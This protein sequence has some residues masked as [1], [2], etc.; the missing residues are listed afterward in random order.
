LNSL[1]VRIKF[2]GMMEPVK[3]AY[4]KKYGQTVERRVKGETSGDHE[5]ILVSLIGGN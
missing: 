5:R 4:F 3:A 1:I 2:F